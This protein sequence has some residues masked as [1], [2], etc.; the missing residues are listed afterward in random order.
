M[1]EAEAPESGTGAQEAVSITV[2]EQEA[3]PPSKPMF[4]WWSL[5]RTLI[6]Y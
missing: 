2:A 4:L 3:V 6:E 5:L 1:L